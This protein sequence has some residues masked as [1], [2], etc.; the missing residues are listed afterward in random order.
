MTTRLYFAPRTR[1]FTA[2]WLMEEL[3]HPYEL[4]SFAIHDGRHK[5]DD[6][7]ALNPMGKVPLVV[8]DGVPISETGA[9]ALYLA[10]RLGSPLAPKLD[11]AARAEFLRWMFFAGSVTE[12]AFAEKLFKWEVSA[13]SVA[14]GS[15]ADMQRM[16][17]AGVTPGPWLLGDRFTVADVVVGASARFGVMFGVFDKEGPIADYVSRL[18]ERDA[19]KRA[20]VIEAREG[21]RFPPKT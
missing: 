1:A 4:E 12:P 14:W 2:L 16:L 9:I 7:L 18:S 5:K 3:G 17:M 15:F 6:Y 11:D 19:Y 13:S 8:H 10:D 21:E 20:E